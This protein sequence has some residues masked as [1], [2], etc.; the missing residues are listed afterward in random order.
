MY[1]YSH[2]STHGISGQAV[3]GA[4]EQ[5]EVRLI[6]MIMWTQRY[7]PRLWSSKFGDAL[8]GHACANL[9]AVIE[10][11]WKYTWKTWLSKFGD[12]P[13]G[14]AHANLEDIIERLW[15]YTCR[16]WSNE[17]GDALGG[18][19][20]VRVDEYLEPVNGERAGCLDSIHQLVNS[21]PWECDNVTWSFELSWR[22][23]RWRSTW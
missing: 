17:F 12:A 1:L 16:P 9:E 4:W 13:R 23:G 5:F 19:D 3:C 10:Q 6:M 20:W 15:I 22:A 8:G 11:V 21:Q 18:C 14:L 7:T 2:P